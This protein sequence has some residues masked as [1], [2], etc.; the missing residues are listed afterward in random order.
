MKIVRSAQNSLAGLLRQRESIERSLRRTLS[1]TSAARAGSY[2]QNPWMRY[3][4]HAL[5]RL[6]YIYSEGDADMLGVRV[7]GSPV[8]SGPAWVDLTGSPDAQQD[9]EAV[10]SSSGSGESVVCLG[11]PPPLAPTSS[12]GSGESVVCLGPPPP[13]PPTPVGLCQE[14]SDD[15]DSL[16]CAE[17]EAEASSDDDLIIDEGEQ[18]EVE[19]ENTSEGEE[20]VGE[21]E[22]DGD[23]EDGAGPAEAEGGEYLL[24]AF[25]LSI[26][27]V[28]DVVVEVRH[29]YQD[30]E[31]PA[32]SAEI[33]C[34]VTLMM[35]AGEEIIYRS[36]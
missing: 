33:E 5:N 25:R 13:P 3:P 35:F 18:V 23:R 4:G 30:Q 31:G 36:E 17:C 24:N 27:A 20:I 14:Q 11:P 34:A 28:F 12:S 32:A 19:P 29:G 16:C 1:V 26:Q 15:E 10:S 22:G 7:W 6:R 21:G 8:T 2:P 9:T